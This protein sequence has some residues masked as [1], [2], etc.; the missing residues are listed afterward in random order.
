MLAGPLQQVN[1]IV[2]GGQQIRAL[3]LRRLHRMDVVSE[4]HA[5]FRRSFP[6]SSG[7]VH[8]VFRNAIRLQPHRSVQPVLPRCRSGGPMRRSDHQD[9][10]ARAVQVGQAN[11]V[12]GRNVVADV[13]QASRDL[14][15]SCR[16]STTAECRPCGCRR[17]ASPHR[18]R[19]NRP[20]RR[21]QCRPR[22]RRRCRR[23]CPCR[24]KV[25]LPPGRILDTRTIRVWID[26]DQIRLAVAV[27][28]GQQHGVADAKTVIDFLGSAK[29]GNA[30][31]ALSSPRAEGFQRT[32]ASAVRLAPRRSTKRRGSFIGGFSRTPMPVNQ[33]RTI[34]F[35]CRSRAA[36]CGARRRLRPSTWPC[37]P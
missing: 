24:M 25:R 32:A 6:A 35:L 10:F 19:R 2:A 27:D 8:R 13:V 9:R 31:A 34:A 7:R 11:A 26:H 12:N 5:D 22:Q 17:A 18:A 36:P 33:T 15:G 21:H 4:R 28:I 3:A 20:C 30:D 16:D 29:V 37:R 14:R 23:V 1:A